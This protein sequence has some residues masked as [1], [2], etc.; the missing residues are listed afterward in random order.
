[1]GTPDSRP[2]TIKDVSAYLHVHTTT[3]YCALKHG[4][5]PAFKLGGNWGFN[6]EPIDR[7][8]LKQERLRSKFG[9]RSF[10]SRT[11]LP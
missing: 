10:Q 5:L 3:E 6:A 11:V 8:R 4:Q 2:I 7:W 1:M 9:R